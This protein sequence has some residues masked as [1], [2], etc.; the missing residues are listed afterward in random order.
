MSGI[1][2]VRGDGRQDLRIGTGHVLR[3]PGDNLDKPGHERDA[4]KV[5]F[6]TGISLPDTQLR[7][8]GGNDGA[9][10]LDRRKSQS[11]GDHT[12]YRKQQGRGEAGQFKHVLSSNQ[13]DE[14]EDGRA[15]DGG[16][17]AG[18]ENQRS[19]EGGTGGTH[20]EDF[21]SKGRVHQGRG[22]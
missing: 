21:G 6:G 1:C 4:D 3:R 8:V 7:S 16:H 15:G 17:A 19:H 18:Q 22:K 2:D 20:P 11:A 13:H 5:Y 12:V 9:G 14:G 10:G